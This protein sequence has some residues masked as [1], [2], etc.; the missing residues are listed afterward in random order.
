[1]EH[2]LSTPKRLL[3]DAA[4]LREEEEQAKDDEVD[5]IFDDLEGDID[6]QYE[7]EYSSTRQ[8]LFDDD[9]LYVS[10][11][12]P[13][14]SPSAKLNKYL[15]ESMDDDY[16]RER[17]LRRELSDLH[18]K[19]YNPEP[20]VFDIETETIENENFREVLY[21]GNLEITLMSIPP[22]EN[23]D[24]EVHSYSDQFIRVE[25]GTGKLYIDYEG[26]SNDEIW[27]YDLSEGFAAVIPAGIYHEIVNTSDRYDLKIYSI[28]SPNQHRPDMIDRIKI[29][30]PPI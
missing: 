19:M 4:R 11:R 1:M 24:R 23:V 17:E 29:I 3:R 14:V 6:E 10:R 8:K 5:D 2:Y 12:S 13:P 25:A 18:K 15:E 28:Y 16:R 26:E 9:D 21:V 30:S 22:G 27:E 7:L 20:L